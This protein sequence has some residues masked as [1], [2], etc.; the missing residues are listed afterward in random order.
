MR[1]LPDIITGI[2]GALI[3]VAG[4]LA[5]FNFIDLP[6]QTLPLVTMWVGI[7]MMGDVLP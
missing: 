2:V 1:R 6:E 5:I 7:L 4:L 3:A